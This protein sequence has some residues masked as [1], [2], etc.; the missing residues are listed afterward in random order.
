M[1]YTCSHFFA[2]Y[3]PQIKGNIACNDVVRFMA[4]IYAIKYT[5]CYVAQ[6][7]KISDKTY[8]LHLHFLYP[9]DRN[10]TFP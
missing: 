8:F 2:N 5:L 1:K 6:F 9:E 7:I 10:K 4:S 3:A